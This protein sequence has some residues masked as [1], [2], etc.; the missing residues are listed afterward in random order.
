[1][2]LSILNADEKLAYLA[3]DEDT[4]HLYNRR[5]MAMCDETSWRNYERGEGRAEGKLE[6]AGKMKAIGRPLK[7]IIEF[8]GLSPEA[9][10]HI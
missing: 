10:E 8:T 9:I 6:V 4:I 2:D 3:G 7:E 5:F 1:M